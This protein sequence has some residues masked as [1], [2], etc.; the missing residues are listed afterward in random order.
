MTI[1]ILRVWEVYAEPT[2]LTTDRVAL[3]VNE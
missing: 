2:T 1:V 3:I